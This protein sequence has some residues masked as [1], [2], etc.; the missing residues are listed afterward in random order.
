M[1]CPRYDIQTLSSE[2][3]QTREQL[4]AAFEEQEAGSATYW[5]AFETAAFFRTIGSSWSPAHTVRHL[6]KSL[7]PVVKA[8]TMPKLLLRLMFGRA[9]RPSMTYDDFVAR[10]QKALAEG[11]KAGRFGPSERAEE[12]VEAWRAAIMRDFAQLNVALR[13]A[14][15]RWPEGK[16]DRLLLPHPLLGKLTVREMLFFTLYHQRHHIAVV[17]RRLKENATGAA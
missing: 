6:S 1:A 4:L 5:R 16:L 13:N 9:R 3:P 8:L 17:E 14:I 10:Y 7:R 11:G 12:D 15:R 2:S